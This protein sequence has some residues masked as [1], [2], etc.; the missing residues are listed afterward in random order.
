MIHT[1]AQNSCTH[2]HNKPDARFL[3]IVSACKC[4]RSVVCPCRCCSFWGVGCD[5]WWLS[6]ESTTRCLVGLTGF[7]FL[8]ERWK[9]NGPNR[10]TCGP[11]RLGWIHHSGM[12]SM[13]EARVTKAQ[14]AKL[15][16]DSRWAG[17]GRFV[18]DPMEY[19]WQVNVMH[20][21]IWKQLRVTL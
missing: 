16:V 1:N 13:G 6:Y 14:S 9:Y 18:Y 10:M 21:V 3:P 12:E 4:L 19:F 15:Q 17:P 2:A 5:F 20:D 8:F 11:R 7:F